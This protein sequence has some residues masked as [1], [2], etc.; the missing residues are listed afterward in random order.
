MSQKSATQ[1]KGQPNQSQNRTQ[2]YGNR[3]PPP[4]LCKNFDVNNFSFTEIGENER[5]K[6]QLISYPRYND[7]QFVFQTPEFQITQ[8]GLPDLG[9]FCK[10]D[11][12]RNYIKAPLDPDQQGCREIE[13]M[14]S[15][16]DKY[17]QKNQNTILGRYVSSKSKY[18]FTTCVKEPQEPEELEDASDNK[19]ERKPKHKYW[20]A[21]FDLS[22]PE[23]KIL[24]KVYVRRTNENGQVT[25]EQV[26]V[27]NATEMSE[28]LKWGSRIRMIVM[29]N[30]LW[31]EKTK[32][33]PRSEFK[34][35]GLTFKIM[36]LEI[37][38]REKAG[39]MKDA[40]GQFAFVDDDSSNNNTSNDNEETNDNNDLD[41]NIDNEQE[42]EN[43][44]GE[45]EDE[46]QEIEQA[47]EEQT[48]EEQQEDEQADDEQEELEETEEEPPKK[49]TK[50]V[51]TPPPAKSTGRTNK[52][53]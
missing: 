36:Q 1:K 44:E 21:K 49:P 20:R 33:D 9:E 8:Y 45:Q 18:S 42:E 5:S 30:K 23:Q 35:Y 38:P 43:N 6:A 3:A 12:D 40:F 16:I 22:Y 24:T 2:N 50:K 39:S 14:L 51:S 28:Y 53:K 7:S 29:M 17:V 11:N 46:Q 37:E 41:E 48:E 52:K 10:T 27:T 15:K 13:E 25:R 32:K 34:N 26:P 47:E 31:A 4:V 19:K